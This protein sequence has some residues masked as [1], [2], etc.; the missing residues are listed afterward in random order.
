MPKQAFIISLFFALFLLPG[1]SEAITVDEHVYLIGAGSVD[2][3]VLEKIKE[4]FADNFPAR[5]KVVIDERREIPASAYDPSRKQY[6]AQAVLDDISGR[7][8]IAMT[9][10]RILVVVDSDLYVPG[11]SYVLG[12]A[13]AK[14]GI[15][16][17]SLARLK[18]EFYGLKKDDRLF[19]DRVLKEAIREVG[20]SRGLSDCPNPKC[21]M[22]SSGVVSDSDKKRSAFCNDCQLKLHRSYNAPLFGPISI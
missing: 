21:V 8:T 5:V 2:K 9:D 3:V 17:M 6:N 12:L 18:N 13:E 16:I 19:Y 7:I 10:E 1:I 14:R 11:A 20:L 4:H 15:S 22:H